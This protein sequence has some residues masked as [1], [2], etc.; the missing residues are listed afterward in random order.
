M[1]TQIATIDYS[2]AIMP[3]QD[4]HLA[5]QDAVAWGPSLTI[6]KGQAIGI[7]TSDKLTYAYNNGNADGTEVCKGVSMYSFMTDAQGRVF[8]GGTIVA[9][10][11]NPPS[12]TSPVWLH[13]VFV[14]AKLTGV[15][16]AAIVD[17]GGRTRPNGFLE[18]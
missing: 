18:F 9:S 3:D 15:D 4:P 8:Y 6:T 12:D 7:K 16:A 17:L 5:V 11:E 2:N 13:G 10:R 1:F 14:P